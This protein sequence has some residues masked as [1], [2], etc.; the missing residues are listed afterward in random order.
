MLLKAATAIA[1]WHE[2]STAPTFMFSSSKLKTK[3][4]IQQYT[5]IKRVEYM[6]L[7]KDTISIG[8]TMLVANI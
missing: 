7:K 3:I 5:H 1:F 8:E 6:I 2:G 4:E